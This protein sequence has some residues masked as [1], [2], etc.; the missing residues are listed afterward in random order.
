M[1]LDSAAHW[2]ERRM[3][4]EAPHAVA[5]LCAEHQAEMIKGGRIRDFRARF[6]R[7]AR[8]ANTAL[9]TPAK[10][11]ASGCQPRAGESSAEAPGTWNRVARMASHPG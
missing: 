3:L 5:A 4:R 6:V 2:C 7:R 1:F 10:F 8:R 9:Q 11:V